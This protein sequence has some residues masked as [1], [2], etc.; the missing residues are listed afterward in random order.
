MSELATCLPSESLRV[1]VQKL[2]AYG[3]PRLVV[4]DEAC[5]VVGM[6]SLTDIFRYFT[7]GLEARNEG[8]AGTEKG[9]GSGIARGREAVAEIPPK[10]ED[11]DMESNA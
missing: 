10:E 1:V 11:E 5:R 4:V 9:K 3:V 6:V 7:H 8:G 2:A